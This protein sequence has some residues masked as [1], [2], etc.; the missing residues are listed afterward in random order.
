MIVYVYS[1]VFGR[2]EGKNLDFLFAKCHGLIAR[3]PKKKKM[4]SVVP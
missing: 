1:E 2:L 3:D 4:I